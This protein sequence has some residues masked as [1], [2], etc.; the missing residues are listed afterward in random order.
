MAATT[1]TAVID[2]KS[3]LWVRSA[4]PEDIGLA[5]EIG[6]SAI[7]HVKKVQLAPT[8]VVTLAPAHAATP[9][10]RGQ[11]GEACV[12]DIL[13][14]KYAVT[15]VA[16][17]AKSGD[18]TLMIDH[19]RVCVEVKNYSATVPSTGVEKFQR[20]LASTAAAGGVFISLRTPIAGV[21]T[22]FIVR[23]EPADARTIPCAYIVSSDPAAII[24]AVQVVASMVRAHAHLQSSLRVDNVAAGVHE[25]TGAVENL[26]RLRSDF[27]AEISGITSA[28]VRTDAGIASVASRLRAVST[29]LADDLIIGATCD[30]LPLL[31]KNLAYTKYNA[32]LRAL[33]DRVIGYIGA[34]DCD[35]LCPW[36]VSPRKCQ[37]VSGMGI[38]LL[39]K[40]CYH[41]PRALST[42]E[43]IWGGTVYGKKMTVDADSIVVEIDP[44][45]IDWIVALM[46]PA[47]VP[48]IM[49]LIITADDIEL[50]GSPTN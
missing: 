37:H 36:K 9:V 12:E 4:T 13:R 46:A 39:A 22:D 21:T 14:A 20:D 33:V 50:T 28:M 45:T 23:N 2:A 48:A 32:G 44:V 42:P 1:L 29:Q 5:L 31:A 18:L 26:S 16:K 24:V 15:N 25:I 34:D 47:V 19:H 17:T 7:P 38:S 30:P 6:I 11:I 43:I 40:P 49:P 27:Q 8:P 3:V 35:V 10:M 41:L